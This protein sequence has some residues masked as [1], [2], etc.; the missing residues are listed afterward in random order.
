MSTQL[1]LILGYLSS[2]FLLGLALGWLIWQFGRSKE[3]E[4]MAADTQYWKQRLEQSRF[5][6]NID[7]D[8]VTALE[9][10][11]DNLKRRLKSASSS[12]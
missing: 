10:E 6:R 2:T 3:L 11:R 8:R 5:E 4:S 1:I 7:L 12:N 9:T